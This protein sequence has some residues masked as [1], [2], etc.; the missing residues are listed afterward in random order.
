MVVRDNV[1]FGIDHEARTERVLSAGARL[2]VAIKEIPEE[3]LKRRARRKL[4]A[5]PLLRRF[6]HLTGRDIDNGG[7]QPFRQ[8]R[9]TVGR[10]RRIARRDGQDHCECQTGGEQSLRACGGVTDCSH[11]KPP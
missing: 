11:V 8:V 3:I 6:D 2:A 10:G 1:P 4:R 9:E 7:T 5:F